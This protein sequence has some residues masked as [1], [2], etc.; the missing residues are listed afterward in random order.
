MGN[1]Q[2]TLYTS[3]V[4]SVT[5]CR[6]IATLVGQCMSKEE[7][8]YYLKGV[9]FEN[10][11]VNDD[12]HLAFKAVATDGYTCAVL[13][14]IAIAEGTIAPEVEFSRIFPPKAIEMLAKLDKKKADATFIQFALDGM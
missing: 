12:G 2:T 1:D 10:A 4:L 6:K 13:N 14:I 11:P 8:R 9:L 5:Q 3:F 7:A